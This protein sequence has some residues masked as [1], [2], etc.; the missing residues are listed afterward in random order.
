MKIIEEIKE[1]LKNF[2]E[3]IKEDIVI[4]KVITDHLFRTHLM[5]FL[6]GFCS[7]MFFVFGGGY[8]LAVFLSL[9]LLVYLFFTTYN[10]VKNELIKEEEQKEIRQ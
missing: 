8:A 1:E 3:V 2:K 7:S 5:T 4:K 9:V 6:A 10:K